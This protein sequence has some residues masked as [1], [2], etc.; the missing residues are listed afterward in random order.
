M[1]QLMSALALAETYSHFHNLKWRHWWRQCLHFFLSLLCCAKVN[2]INILRISH[3][4]GWHVTI[5]QYHLISFSV[6]SMYLYWTNIV[7]PKAKYTC[8][9]CLEI[10]TP[11]IA[12]NHFT[13]ACNSGMGHNA[14]TKFHNNI[15]V[16]SAITTLPLPLHYIACQIPL[17]TNHY[18]RGK[19]NMCCL[20]RKKCSEG[21]HDYREGYGE[22]EYLI[23]YLGYS[24]IKESMTLNASVWF[25]P[26]S[27][28]F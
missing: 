6:S 14:C 1:S 24:C 28:F 11:K 16:Y 23:I 7:S 25:C 9:R 10:A 22:F 3:N 4:V 20:L 21:V 8:L 5:S 26:L 19:L 15:N 17:P 13:H 2:R 12:R 18:V 27:Q